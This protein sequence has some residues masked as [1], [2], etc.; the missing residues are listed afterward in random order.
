MTREGLNQRRERLR[1]EA[2][3]DALRNYAAA[4]SA[5]EGRQGQPPGPGD[6]LLAAETSELPIEW[7]IIEQ[8]PHDMS[9]CLAVPADFNPMAGSADVE[10]QNDRA[11]GPLTLRCK[12]GI[13]IDSAAFDTHLRSGFLLPEDVRRASRK[14]MQIEAGTLEASAAQQDTDDDPEYQDWIKNV[15]TKAGPSLQRRSRSVKPPPPAEESRPQRRHAFHHPIAAAAAVLFL[16]GLAF[17]SGW[18]F[19]RLSN[20][21]EE[22]YVQRIAALED[23]LEAFQGTVPALNLQ[24][25]WLTP[26]ELL[27]SQPEIIN[28]SPSKNLFLIVEHPGR[29]RFDL[30]RLE[31]FSIGAAEPIWSASDL[32]GFNTSLGTVQVSAGIS[33]RALASGDFELRLS[34][35]HDEKATLIQKH[36]LRIMH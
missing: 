21:R 13:W 29:Q 26:G 22:Q 9:R 34:G 35:L 3:G 2:T 4:Q 18:M 20:D 7:A 31:I 25:I 24:P 27:R 10:V 6:L 11:T 28:M 19:T 17:G 12:F 15:L 36:L 30:Y 1:H 33:G 14:L 5:I 32:N 23:R 16:I 8:D